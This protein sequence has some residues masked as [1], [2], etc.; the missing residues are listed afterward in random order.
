MQPTTNLQ[1]QSSNSIQQPRS[2]IQAGDS[3]I[4]TQTFTQDQLVAPE[5]RVGNTTVGQQSY[6][7]AAAPPTSHH[8]VG[9]LWLLIPLIVALLILWPRTQT[10]IVE[11]PE[12]EVPGQ[13]APVKKQP[14]RPKSRPTKRRQA[15]R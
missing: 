1:E 11:T 15:K 8:G 6:V 12:P 5:L 9:L 13:P 2:G 14:K 7:Q 3:S 10:P 4:S